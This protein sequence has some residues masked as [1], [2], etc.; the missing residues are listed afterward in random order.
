[1]PQNSIEALESQWIEIGG[2]GN[3]II[4]RFV[5]RFLCH[6]TYVATVSNA[7]N[8]A[9]IVLLTMIDCLVD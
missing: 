9:S 5:K 3:E 6:S 1:M 8:S 4:R 7:I 2:R